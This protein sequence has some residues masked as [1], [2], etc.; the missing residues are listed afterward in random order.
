MS[1]NHAHFNLFYGD[2]DG[3]PNKSGHLPKKEM[4]HLVWCFVPQL[5]IGVGFVWAIQI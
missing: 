4:P 1:Y 2:H 5:Q 3:K